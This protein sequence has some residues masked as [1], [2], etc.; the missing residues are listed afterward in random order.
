MRF[1]PD[2]VA[3]RPAHGAV[4]SGRLRLF[5]L[6]LAV[7]KVIVAAAGHAAAVAPT[8]AVTDAWIRWLP[9]NL[10]AAGYATLR[11]LGEE[12]L[13][14]IGAST[15]DY[16]AVMFHESHN[17]AGVE[18]MLPVETIL[19]K[20]QAEVAFAPGGYHIMLM[21]PKRALQ[22]GDHVLLTFHFAEGQSLQAQFEV[23]KPD[24]SRAERSAS[25]DATQRQ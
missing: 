12:P 2:A 6:G 23:R 22:P 10:P 3:A 19:I 11:N 5:I 13:T 21:E 24:G 1:N 4:C 18:K 16:G 8:L 9:V 14:L 15:P 17:R 20:A 25:F 7:V